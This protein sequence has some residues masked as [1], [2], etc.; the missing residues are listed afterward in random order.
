M[1]KRA[2]WTTLPVIAAGLLSFAPFLYLA[3][4]RRT[5]R[6]RGLLAAFGAATLVE[7]VLLGLVG[8]DRAEGIP[9][10]LVGVYIVVLIAI[11]AIMTWIEMRPGKE[12]AA[13]P[14]RAYL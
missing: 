12:A 3:L 9:D 6:D 7:V 8:T 2:A 1:L 11:T 10:F 13:L 5:A 4:T 14:G